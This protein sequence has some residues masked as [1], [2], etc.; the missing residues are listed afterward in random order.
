MLSD[1]EEAIETIEEP[2]K[3]QVNDERF[4]RPLE[5]SEVPM[6][7]SKS[8]NDITWNKVKL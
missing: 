1:K 2:L 6:E 8:S 4:R 3:R 7:G 5:E